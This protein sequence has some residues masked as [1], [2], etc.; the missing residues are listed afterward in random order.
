[1]DSQVSAFYKRRPELHDLLALLEAGHAF[2]VQLA[3]TTTSRVVDV[4]DRLRRLVER[5]WVESART[6]SVSGRRRLRH[7]LT[8]E[9]RFVLRAWDTGARVP[10]PR[11]VDPEVTALALVRPDEGR[12]RGRYRKRKNQTARPPKTKTNRISATARECQDARA[13][14]LGDLTRNQEILVAALTLALL[15]DRPTSWE[16]QTRP[17]PV[18]RRARGLNHVASYREGDFGG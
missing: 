3:R 12:A 9:G 6:R 11:P 4:Q 18:H 15:P 10:L 5:G 2:D 8:H 7:V 17:T 16:A 1:M 13:L 14:E